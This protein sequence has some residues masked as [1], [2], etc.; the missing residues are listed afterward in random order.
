DYQRAGAMLTVE[1]D[2]G[3]SSRLCGVHLLPK[4]SAE[5]IPFMRASRWL[6]SAPSRF[7]MRD[8]L[9]QHI[10]ASK[11]L[12][13]NQTSVFQWLAKLLSRLEHSLLS[14]PRRIVSKWQKF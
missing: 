8:I 1:E 5:V 4:P 3:G 2:I 10:R 14:P 11:F 13:C 7:Y 12:H 9:S 6:T